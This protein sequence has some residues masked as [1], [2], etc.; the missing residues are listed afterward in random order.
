MAGMM[1]G[2]VLE[3]AHA[4]LEAL[5]AVFPHDR[6]HDG[7]LVLQHREDV[8]AED[9]GAAGKVAET[10]HGLHRVG[11]GDASV[12]ELESQREAFV[13][14]RE[15]EVEFCSEWL[16]G[17]DGGRGA[18]GVYHVA[19]AVQQAAESNLGEKVPQ[20]IP[21]SGLVVF[22]F[23]PS[24]QTDSFFKLDNA[25]MW[26]VELGEKVGLEEKSV[27]IDTLREFFGVA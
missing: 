5:V 23:E 27:P 14:L 4:G 10:E 25:R 6:V 16:E 17:G 2:D 1:R 22:F 3:L 21:S 9:D 11:E 13:P 20:L 12:G 7:V 26:K 15:L 8:G 24:G 19:D 18:F